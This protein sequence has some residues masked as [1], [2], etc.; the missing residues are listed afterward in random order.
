MS[1][2]RVMTSDYQNPTAETPGLSPS[3]SPRL[4]RCLRSLLT[5]ARTTDP[6]E[7]LSGPA[8]STRPLIGANVCVGV[9]S[10]H[11][12]DLSQRSFFAG[13][14]WTCAI[15]CGWSIRGGHRNIATNFRYQRMALKLTYLQLQTENVTI[16]FF[17][18][19]FF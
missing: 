4:Q 5:V 6:T 17:L 1:N 2:E 12:I 18:I 9:H 13:A 15:A 10:C 14:D 7:G 16:I 8:H 3:H 19:S 11:A